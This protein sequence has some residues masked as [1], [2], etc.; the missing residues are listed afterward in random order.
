MKTNSHIYDECKKKETKPTFD[1][2]KVSLGNGSI[3]SKPYGE[4]YIPTPTPY[5]PSGANFQVCLSKNTTTL[6]EGL[7]FKFFMPHDWEYAGSTLTVMLSGDK[8][9]RQYI[10]WDNVV[11]PDYSGAHLY[12]TEER[13]PIWS[14]YSFSSWSS[15]NALKKVSIGFLT[16][17]FRLRLSQ[18]GKTSAWS[19]ISSFNLTFRKASKSVEGTDEDGN[20]ITDETGYL[21]D[22][23]YYW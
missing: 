17:F 7:R 20:E 16:R 10:A 19:S 6:K 8:F 3:Y 2:E 14:S 23:I 11:V 21:F 1:L 22:G 9:F 18:E 5:F 12:K 13:Y 4:V 15:F